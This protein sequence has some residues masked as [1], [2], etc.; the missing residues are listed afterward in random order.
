ML[1]RARWTGRSMGPLARALETFVTTRGLALPTDHAD[2]PAAGRRRRRI[3]AVPEPLRPAVESFAE[4]L[5]RSRERARWT[6]T[7]P[8]SDLAI[9]RALGT[10]RD[11][12]EHL[13]DQRG[14]HAWALVDVGDIEAFLAVLPASRARRLTIAASSSAIQGVPGRTVDQ[15]PSMTRLVPVT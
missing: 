1:E 6:G 8:R 15:P 11:L 5:L 2:R 9:D 13:H 10:V 12:A 7:L 4:F 3:D 14:K